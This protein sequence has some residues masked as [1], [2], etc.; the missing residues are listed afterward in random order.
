MDDDEAKQAWKSGRNEGAMS[1]GWKLMAAILYI[2]PWVDIT[3][4]SIYFTERFPAFAWMEF[5]T[6]GG[7][8]WLQPR[9][10]VGNNQVQEFLYMRFLQ[11]TCDIIDR[12]KTHHADER[13]RED[14]VSKT[15]R[16]FVAL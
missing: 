2:L 1:W 13:R 8:C 12:C 4:K 10:I 15:S 7:L 3:E 11:N 9:A 6:G 5:F 14:R 16:L